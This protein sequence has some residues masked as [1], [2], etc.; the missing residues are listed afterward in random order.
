MQHIH[1]LAR[2]F[3]S[4][5]HIVLMLLLTTVDHTDIAKV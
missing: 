3:M 1:T 4:I 2:D 5:V